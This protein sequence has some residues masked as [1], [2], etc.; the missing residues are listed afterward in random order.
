[1]A[2]TPSPS[3]HRS[4]FLV[5]ITVLLAVLVIGLLVAGLVA[6]RLVPE[7]MGVLREMRQELQATR[8]ATQE[9]RAEV[10]RMQAIATDAS[11]QAA[12]RQKTLRARLEARS[13]RTAEL[14]D[15]VEKRR[16]RVPAKVSANPLAKLDTVIELNKIMAD[17]ILILNRHLAE[18]QEELA[19]AIAPLPIQAKPKNP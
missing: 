15:E 9:L 1:M 8:V 13:K 12:E 7:A 10:D 14:L 2:T 16:K 17:E 3:R 6:L 4:G 18:T 5:A 11:T 19:E